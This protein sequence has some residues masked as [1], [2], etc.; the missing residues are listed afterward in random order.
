MVPRNQG[1]HCRGECRGGG[2]APPDQG[3]RSEPSTYG[4]WVVGADPPALSHTYALAAKA[5]LARQMPDITHGSEDRQLRLTPHWPHGVAESR[6]GGPGVAPR[7]AGSG[8][9]ASGHART[10]PG[11]N[12][13]TQPAAEQPDVHLDQHRPGAAWISVTPPPSRRD[14]HTMSGRQAALGQRDLQGWRSKGSHGSL[15][16]SRL[17]ELDRLQVDGSFSVHL[18]SR[19]QTRDRRSKWKPG[20]A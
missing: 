6:F 15:C 14:R 2:A 11:P 4:G 12:H 16:R 19:I 13:E 8:S 1:C 5:G 18:D 10:G 9:G 7:Q 3:R 20:E 17:K